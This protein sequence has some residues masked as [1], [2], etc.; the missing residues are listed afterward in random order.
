MPSSF[1][2]CFLLIASSQG[3]QQANPQ[4]PSPNYGLAPGRPSGPMRKGW[5]SEALELIARENGP[6][7]DEYLMLDPRAGDGRQMRI[8]W[9]KKRCTRVSEPSDF[10]A[11]PDEFRDLEALGR[12]IGKR[13]IVTL[14]EASHS[15]GAAFRTKARL[16][17]YLHE[18]CGFDVL[19]FESGL[20]D[21][22]AAWRRT[23]AGQPLP[24]AGLAALQPVW[25][26]SQTVHD[27]LAW[28]DAGLAS[29][30]PLQ[31]AGMDLMPTSRYMT[32]AHGELLAMGQVLGLEPEFL[33]AG[34]FPFEDFPAR[35]QEV[36]KLDAEERE[37]QLADLEDL[38]HAFIEK[39]RSIDLDPKTSA[40]AKFYAQFIESFSRAIRMMAVTDFS[41][42]GGDSSL[43][44]RDEQM[45]ANVV[46]LARVAHPDAKLIIWGATSHLS[47]ARSGLKVQ[48]APDMVPV[49][50]HLSRAMPGEVYH[51]GV[52]SYA[53]AIGGAGSRAAEELDPA[54]KGSFEELLYASGLPAAF[55][56]FAG[57]RGQANW[58]H[59]GIS[60]RAMGHGDVHGDWAKALDGV[61]FV[62]EA[63]PVLT[64]T[65]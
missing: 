17:R 63:L 42:P 10:D 14:G 11:G 1:A 7:I 43:N 49:G 12:A 13:R 37:F 32:E 57:L 47:R 60:M 9:L 53:G 52:T 6:P 45:A 23:L 24:E 8:E 36:V 40:R 5:P 44:R 51:L 56:D 26:R 33:E 2:L 34:L 30:H 55:L 21:C 38:G 27:L 3:P 31:L 64:L 58:L 22:D 16:V 18:K 28:M 50:E 65:K 15:D 4:P 20:F 46:W 35:F 41:V 59:E 29:E 61:Y 62:R 48:T 39:E 19:V 25:A 54:P